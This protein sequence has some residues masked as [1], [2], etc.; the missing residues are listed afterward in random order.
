MK[1]KALF[2]CGSINQTTMMHEISKHLVGFESYFTPYYDDGIIGSLARK[3]FLEFTILGNK[4]RR[5]TENYLINNGLNVDPDKRNNEYDLIFTCSDLII[6]HNIRSDKVILVQEGMTDPENLMY[7]LVKYLGFPRYLAS[8]STTALSNAYK[9]FF[10][11]SEGYKKLFIKKGVDPNKIVVTGTPNF[12]NLNQYLSNDFPYKNYVLVAT[13]D[14][15]ETFKYENR[16]MFIRK[17]LEIANGRQIIF[18]LHPNENFKRATKEI[19]I[20]APGSIVFTSGNINQM[21]ANCDVLITKYSTVVYVG[22]VLKKE[23]YSYFDLTLLK[24][25]TPIQNNGE[26]AKLIAKKSTD[27]L[28]STNSVIDYND[29]YLQLRNG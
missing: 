16:K 25:L 13:S 28:L 18:K 11:A 29:F 3:G 6:P 23:V 7:Y 24:E 12:D 14:S 15:R 1:N 26:S 10:V 21:I 20:Y 19:N 9:L 2:I 17:A 5:K 27:Y 22:I 4:L 8:T